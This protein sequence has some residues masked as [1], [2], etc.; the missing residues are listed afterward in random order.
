MRCR[1]GEGE[2]FTSL[3][4]ARWCLASAA[5]CSTRMTC[6][7]RASC[8]CSTT[9]CATLSLGS[10]I[11]SSLSRKRYSTSRLYLCLL[12]FFQL[13]SRSAVTAEGGRG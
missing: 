12:S 5:C 10:K 9:W 13:F 1:A 6:S 4:C 8:S 7:T 2:L 3:L 11:C